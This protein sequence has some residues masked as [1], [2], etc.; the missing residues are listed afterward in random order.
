M[1]EGVRCA[2]VLLGAAD[3]GPYTPVAVWPDAKLSMNHL[4]GAAERALRERRGLLVEN[5]PDENGNRPFPEPFH[6]A[7][8]IE[9]SGKLHGVVVLGVER[10]SRSEVQG[11][12]RQLHWGA[13]WIEVLI[14]RRE[15]D[16]AEAL[17]QRMQKVLALLSSAAEQERFQSS[18]MTL[19]T[20]LATEVECDRV[21]L[22]VL[23][24]S[25]VRL[26]VI[27]HSADFGKQMNLVRAIEAAMEEAVD[28][29]SVIHYPPGENAPPLVTRS[30]EALN[31]KHGTGILCTF[32]LEN[33]G[34]CM[35]ALM[36]ERPTDRP[37]SEETVALIESVASLTGPLLEARRVEERWIGRK[38]YDAAVEQL[39][40]LFGPRHPVRKAVA[41]LLVGFVAFV[42]LYH[43]DYRVTAPTAL[44]GSVQ[45]VVAAPFSGYIIEAPARPGDVV[46]QGEV[47]CRLDD[48][49]LVLERLRWLTER[50]QYSK[51]Y[52]AALARHD[53]SKIR[54]LRAKI[55]Q[56]DAQL[57][58]IEEQLTRTRINAPFDGVVM[59]GDLS[60][61]LGSPVER[62]EVLF[63]VAPLDSY[64]VIAQVDERDI[65]QIRQGQQSDLVLSSMPG[66]VFS[67][68]V[69]RITPVSVAKEGRNYFRV[70]GKMD[71]PSDRLRPGMEGIG[72]IN[73]GRH[74]LIW[75]W[76]HEAID[77][78]RLQF[79]RWRP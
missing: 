29:S 40:K 27:S 30:H 5:P 45:R 57:T 56:A 49:D 74:R 12:M 50:D 63:E 32:P 39:K 21:S 70:E 60:Q 3:R 17:S 13:A 36:L 20:Q 54:V 79:W 71:S 59:S 78:L 38:I 73:A 67:F 19:V 66:D 47:L 15:A 62:G 35:G 42:S 76:T 9:V 37:F 41:V 55:E 72:K 18:A 24:G 4:T 77:W 8:P 7:Y 44:E 65:G 25:K 26:Q 53:R 51:E 31:R 28:Q 48:R 68:T 23:V 75:V 64:R 6:V 11:V 46:S 69:E 1:L 58:L 52:Q 61:S 34:R 43:V 14:R 22:G 33:G 10:A 2:M 16:A